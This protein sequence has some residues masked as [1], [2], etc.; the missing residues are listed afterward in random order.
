MG[1]IFFGF[2]FLFA[3][4]TYPA[5]ARG[6][7][8]AG[9]GKG[10]GSRVSGTKLRLPSNFVSSGGR[11]KVDSGL[12][13]SRNSVRGIYIRREQ[14]PTRNRGNFGFHAMPGGV[15]RGK[16][17]LSFP[18]TVTFHQVRKRAN[19]G[20]EG[21]MKLSRGL[22]RDF[23]SER[24]SI[25]SRKHSEIKTVGILKEGIYRG[26]TKEHSSPFIKK[27]IFHW[28]DKRDVLHFS[29]NPASVYDTSGDKKISGG[30]GKKAD[31]ELNKG[32]SRVFINV[33]DRAKEHP[34]MT[35]RVSSL[36]FSKPISQT[37]GVKVSEVAVFDFSFFLFN[38]FFLNNFSL[39]FQGFVFCP[40]A[41]SPLFAFRPLIPSPFFA[42]RPLIPFPVFSQF[43]VLR[44]LFLSFVFNPLPFDPV[45]IVFLSPF[46]IW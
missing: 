33:A 36:D 14:F 28:V 43:F 4:L 44:P 30:Y 10:F 26:H 41:V 40:V 1:K 18:N 2:I 31:S 39:C 46:V 29:N 6:F 3:L 7:Q 5:Q 17:A 19:Y 21:R 20:I 12:S 38:P 35:R 25:T 32:A 8:R 13:G 16:G 9:F 11:V 34:G 23:N 42:F 27:R 22:G 37:S 45:F 15:L 24:G